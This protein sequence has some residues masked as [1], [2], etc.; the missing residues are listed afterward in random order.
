MPEQVIE[1]PTYME[2]I[3]HFFED[4]DLE[5]MYRLGIDLSTYDKLKQRALRVYLQTRPPTAAMPPEPDR[6]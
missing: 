2:H 4:V 1:H 3:R 5:H 6:K